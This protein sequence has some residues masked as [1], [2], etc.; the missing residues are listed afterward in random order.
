MG[1]RQLLFVHVDVWEVEMSRPTVYV[2]TT[3]IGHLVGRVLKDPIVAGRQTVT[4]NWWPFALANY[5][6]IVSGLVLEECGAGDAQAAGERLTVAGSLE[7]I[8]TSQEV[9]ELAEKL[10]QFKAIPQTELR[11]AVHVSLAAVN[12]IEYLATWN[13][14]HIANVSTRTAIE[15]VCRS[16]GYEP[17]NICTPDE[18]MGS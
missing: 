13:F 12:G 16:A 4:R 10:L 1:K 9:D 3:V 8:Q 11:D 15:S 7:L 14:R 2:E 6:L 17:P 5:R 18:L